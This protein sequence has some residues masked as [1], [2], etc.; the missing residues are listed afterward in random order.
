M[1]GCDTFAYVDGR[2]RETRAALN[3]DDPAGT[4][5][6]DMV[7]NAMPSYANA[8]SSEPVMLE[9]LVDYATPRTYAD[10]F[11]GID[12]RQVVVVTGEEDN[13]FAPGMPVG[14]VQPPPG[15][16]VNDGGT[17]RPDASG[18][19]PVTPSPSASGPL[20]S[21]SPASPP[22]SAPTSSGTPESGCACESAP[23]APASGSPYLALGLAAAM[24]LVVTRRRR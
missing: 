12:S 23:G 5:Y 24:G 9:A 10:I 4:K 21:T 19:A 18:E 22:S 14:S 13:E 15:V 16:E 11:R 7:T 17:K 3:A 20:P 6:L 2:L 8:F 1:N